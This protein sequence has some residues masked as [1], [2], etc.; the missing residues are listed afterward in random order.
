[1][2]LKV[3]MWFC[4]VLEKPMYGLIVNQ[5][6]SG[7]SPVVSKLSH[8]HNRNRPKHYKE[9]GHDRMTDQFVVKQSDK[10]F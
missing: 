6:E 1:M 5:T 3:Y 8:G 10:V 7:N 9:P 4:T 2:Q